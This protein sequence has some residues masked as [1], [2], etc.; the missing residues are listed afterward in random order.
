MKASLATQNREDP[1][2]CSG[3]MR[4]SFVYAFGLDS[5]F[6]GL[7]SFV[8]AGF[9]S[10]PPAGFAS[11]PAGGFASF[12]GAAF[13]SSFFSA[14]FASSFFAAGFGAGAAGF[15][16]ASFFTFATRW[17][18][19]SILFFKYAGTISADFAS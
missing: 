16:S 13:A 6:A 7:P 12:A 19:G 1:V 9:S 8:A 4:L 17:S 18:F 15:G 5:A 14:G 3:L 2:S 11:L 10:L